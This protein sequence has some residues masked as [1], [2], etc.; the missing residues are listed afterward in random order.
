VPPSIGGDPDLSVKKGNAI[1]IPLQDFTALDPDDAAKDLIFTVSD[2]TNGFVALSGSPTRPIT[3]FR[4]ADLEHGSV[5][6][7]HD[8]TNTT[9]A[10]FNVAVADRSATTSGAPQT[11]NVSV[12]TSAPAFRRPR[13]N[14][15][16][17]R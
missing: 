6:F 14:C 9:T 3:Q 13:A 1:S 15:S 7:K 2:A 17:C 12:R 16:A 5:M 4:Q 11:V 10:S 8:G